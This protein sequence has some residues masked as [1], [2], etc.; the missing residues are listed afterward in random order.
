MPFNHADNVPGDNLA[1]ISESGETLTYHE[2]YERAAKA[3]RSIVPRKLVLIESVWDLQTACFYVG[4][5]RRDAIVFPCVMNV[6]ERRLSEI[7]I[8][9][10]P[11]FI[12]G[13]ANYSKLLS[14]IGY[15]GRDKFYF[16]IQ[17]E[18]PILDES[19]A[20]LISTSGSSGSEKTVRISKENLKDNTYSII[21]GLKI[22][23]LD[24]AITTLPLSYSYGISIF[25]SHISK[26]AAVVLNRNSLVSKEFWS[27]VR[28]LGV[29]NFGGVPQQHRL[30]SRMTPS[31][32]TKTK[33]RY[34]T[35]AGGKLEIQTVLKLH[36]MLQSQDIGLVKMYGQTEATA[37]ISIMPAEEL[38]ENFDSVGYPILG[39]RIEIRDISTKERVS[40][41]VVGEINYIGKNVMLGYANSRQDLNLGDIN[42]GFLQ[43]GDLGFLDS[44]GRLI[45]Q[46]RIDRV[47]KVAGLKIDLDALESTLSSEE[48]RVVALHGDESISIFIE[49]GRDLMQIQSEIRDYY[50]IAKSTFKL[51]QVD[52]IPTLP[53]GKVNYTELKNLLT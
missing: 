17:Q 35:Q 14:R 40:T 22:R 18:S 1:L 7:V 36:E 32:L 20:M 30:L 29:T 5:L 49:K 31:L 8:K 39:G 44:K 53:S 46:G 42:R 9:Y 24:V 12:Y 13:F 2:M 47:V 16:R 48:Y 25:N 21:E 4:C 11:D 34:V 43:T 3:T 26:G 28:E 38:K 51:I 27:L 33:M 23:E 50:P 41:G 10:K 15:L 37:R 6:S 45:V 52:K 19:L